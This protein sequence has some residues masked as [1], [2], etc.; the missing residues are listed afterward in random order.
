[1]SKLSYYGGRMVETDG[2]PTVELCDPNDNTKK[3]HQYRRTAEG[4][5]ERR[6][7][8][9]HG[10]SYLD[11]SEWEPIPDADIEYLQSVR[12]RWHPILNPLGY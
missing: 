7:L 12:G 5:I 2:I 10:I 3:I 11:G 4:G 8:M 1:M 6:V 9:E